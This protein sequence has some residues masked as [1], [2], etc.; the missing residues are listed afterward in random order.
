MATVRGDRTALRGTLHHHPGLLHPPSRLRSSHGEPLALELCG[1]AATAIT[2]TRVGRNRVDPSSQG[3][4][5]RID[6]SPCVSWQIRIKPT[7][8]DLKHLTED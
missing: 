7:A 6:L 4:F 1:H 2:V 3:D 8:A 5:L